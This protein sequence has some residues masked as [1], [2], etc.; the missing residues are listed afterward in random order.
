MGYGRIDYD[1]FKCP[2]NANL[3]LKL[4]TVKRSSRP[5]KQTPNKKKNISRATGMNMDPTPKLSLIYLFFSSP[6]SHIHHHG[7]ETS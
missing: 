6:R 5:T 2:V 4:P 1:L 7:D 3:T